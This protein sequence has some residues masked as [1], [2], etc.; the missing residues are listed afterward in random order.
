MFL[1]ALIGF[2]T[3]QPTTTGNHSMVAFNAIIGLGYACPI[4]LVVALVQLTVP[5]ELM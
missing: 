2:S 4:V 5:K 3:V 1:I